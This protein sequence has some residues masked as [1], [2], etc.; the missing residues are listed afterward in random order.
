LRVDPESD[1]AKAIM[2]LA[3]LRAGQDKEALRLGAPHI[4]QWPSYDM[5]VACAQHKPDAEIDAIAGKVQGSVDPEANYL[6]AANLAYCGRNGAALALLAKAVEGHYCS[7]PVMDSDPFF[8]GVRNEPEFA[9]VRAAAIAC[10]QDFAA[11]WQ[12]IQHQPSP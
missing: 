7:Y 9:R 11:E 3:L 2:L 6:A 1:F 5:L 4:V 12:R 10:Q 8:N